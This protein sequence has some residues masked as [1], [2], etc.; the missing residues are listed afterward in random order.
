MYRKLLASTALSLLMAGGV[1]AQDVVTPPA[2]PL[3]QAPAAETV[4]TPAVPLVQPA[5]RGINADGWLAT[6]VLGMNIHNSTADD[7]DTIGEVND[8]VLDQNG[9]V[10][11]VIVGVG[12]FLGIGQKNVAINWE[13]LQLVVDADGNQRLVAN[14]TREQIENAADFDRTEWLASERA[15][16]DVFVD[17]QPVDPLGAPADPMAAPAQP[18]PPGAETT[19]VAPAPADQ[20]LGLDWNTYVEVPTGEVSVDEL[21][22]TTVYGAGDENVGSIG[23]VILSDSGSVEAVI[24]DFGGFLGIGT[25]PVAVAFDNLTFLRDNDG[26]LVLR[27]TLSREQL[28]AA[29][30]YNADAYLAAPGENVVIVN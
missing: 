6:E 29:P 20:P 28:D 27:T 25:K 23:D 14:M 1:L 19:P 24:I 22:G 8:F 5:E 7:A 4:E 12:G 21:T 13:E 30:E 3:M 16:A 15:R 26:N 2:D 9:S 11:A 18:A 10:A 17:T